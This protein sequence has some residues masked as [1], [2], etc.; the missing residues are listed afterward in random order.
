MGI[1]KRLHRNSRKMHTFNGGDANM[2]KLLGI[3][4]A[5]FVIWL[6]VDG[7]ISLLAPLTFLL[8]LFP[9]GKWGK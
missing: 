2:F 8:L 4:L 7:L 9:R 6:L 1:S 5:I 3:V